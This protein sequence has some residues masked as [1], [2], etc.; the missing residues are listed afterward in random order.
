MPHGFH[1][2]SCAQLAWEDHQNKFIYL[3]FL[4][5]ACGVFSLWKHKPVIIYSPSC[6][7]KLVQPA[8]LLFG[9]GTTW[10]WVNEAK[11]LDYWVTDTF[12]GRFSSLSVCPTENECE[13]N[14]SPCKAPL[15]T[16]ICQDLQGM[17]F[18]LQQTMSSAALAVCVFMKGFSCFVE[19]T[20]WPVVDFDMLK[21]FFSVW[22][23]ISVCCP[24][25]F[26]GFQSCWWFYMANC[27][28]F[29]QFLMV[30]IKSCLCFPPFNIPFQS[31]ISHYKVI[32]KQIGIGHSIC[33]FINL[34]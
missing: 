17:M 8:S 5:R 3:Y 2:V 21:E 13:W 7:S 18:Y 22:S 15:L 26:K 29:N 32:E 25:K 19:K 27:S 24:I 20:F 16:C 1:Y 11:K 12:K 6:G 23:P 28:E 10:K 9:F 14:S 34:I 30:K 33:W 4:Y 31:E